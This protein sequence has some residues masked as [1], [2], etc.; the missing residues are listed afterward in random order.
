MQD[1]LGAQLAALQKRTE[2]GL[3]GLEQAVGQVEAS[4]SDGL[5]PRLAQL[6]HGAEVLGA[7]LDA[8]EGAAA[9]A[10]S[11]SPQLQSPWVVLTAAVG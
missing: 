11:H 1:E 2:G 7:R 5:Q 9:A 4:V 6:D 10:A 3:A 8:A